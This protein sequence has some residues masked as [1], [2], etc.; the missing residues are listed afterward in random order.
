MRRPPG[1]WV[2]STPPRSAA[3]FSPG[4]PGAAPRYAYGMG[5]EVQV[6]RAAQMFEATERAGV[7][8]AAAALQFSTRDP[9]IHSTIVGASVPQRISETAALL[10]IDIPQASGMSWNRSLPVRSTGSRSRSSRHRAARVGPHRACG[11]P[12]LNRSAFHRP[13]GQSG[14]DLPVEEDVHQQRRNRDQQDVGEQQVPRR[15]E[16]A[17]E[18]VQGELHRGVLCCPGGSTAGSRSR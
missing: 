11:Q 14:H 16:L 18:V 13:R 7:P 9:R 6:Q 1:A 15:L 12:A 5:S 17:L 2:C 3:V 8:L 4:R 10:E